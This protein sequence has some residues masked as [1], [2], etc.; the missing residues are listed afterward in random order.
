MNKLSCLKFVLFVWFV[1][2]FFVYGEFLQAQEEEQTQEPAQETAPVFSYLTPPT[3]KGELWICPSAEIALYSKYSFSYG[4]GFTIAYGRKASI[5][6]KAA[7]FLDE[8]EAL[9]VLELHVLLRLYLVGTAANSGPFLQITGGPAIFFKNIDDIS[10]PSD[11]GLFSA[12][13][14]LGWRFLLGS[15]FFVEPSVRGG[16]P[17]IV[18]GGISLGFRF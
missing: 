16:Y 6:F 13:I 7:F 15:T 11:Y 5:G 10:L 14:S 1:V 4:P 18:G 9:D 17:F 12:S 3:Q 2:N 8:Q